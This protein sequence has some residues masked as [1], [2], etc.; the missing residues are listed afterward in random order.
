MLLMKLEV[1]GFVQKSKQNSFLSH[2][3][4][5]QMPNNSVSPEWKPTVYSKSKC[6][7]APPEKKSLS[8]Y[9]SFFSLFNCAS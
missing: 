4:F 7:S 1:K 6:S 8:M 9:D 5:K 3:Y 2:G